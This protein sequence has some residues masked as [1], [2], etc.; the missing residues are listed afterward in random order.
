MSDKYRLGGKRT[1]RGCDAN[2]PKI[3]ILD[4]L[5]PLKFGVEI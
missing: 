1:W 4:G 2:D 5:T 3:L